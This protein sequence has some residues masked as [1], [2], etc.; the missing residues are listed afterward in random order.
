[1]SLYSYEEICRG[2]KHA[3]WIAA[4]NFWDGQPRFAR[5]SIGAEQE[6]DGCDCTC[7]KKAAVAPAPAAPQAEPMTEAR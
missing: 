6:V 5:C 2:C 4:G 7:P 1:M 3:Q